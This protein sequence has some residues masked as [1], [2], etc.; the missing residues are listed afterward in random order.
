MRF[1]VRYHTFY[2][3]NNNSLR[4]LLF[5]AFLFLTL[6]LSAQSD[7]SVG[8]I[9]KRLVEVL[10]EEHVKPR[11]LDENLAKAIHND[12]MSSLDDEK[13][14]FSNEDIDELEEQNPNIVSDIT[15]EQETYLNTVKKIYNA[16]LESIKGY[17]K[18]FFAAELDLEKP[19]SRENIEMEE[20][21]P[22]SLLGAKWDV[23]FR[24]SIM[25]DVISTLEET[26]FEFN[27]DSLNYIVTDAKTRVESIYSDYFINIADNLAFID[28]IY[29]NSIA[30][31]YDPHSNYF[32]FSQNKEFE[33]ELSSERELFGVS[34]FKNVKGEMEVTSIVPGSS[35]WLSGQVRVGDVIREIKFGNE[36][37]VVL[38]GKT[39]F[40][41]NKLFDDNTSDKVLLTLENENDGIKPVELLKTKVYS[42]DDIIKS[43]LLN[44]EKK[45]G[46]ISLPDFY[47]NWN[48]DGELG[49]ANDLAKTLIKLKKENI[50][51]VILDLR[52]NGGGS[53]KESIDLTGIFI[54]YGPI[55]VVDGD[56]EKPYTYKDFNRGAIYNGPLIVM[57]NENSASASEVV[58]GA[59]QDYN[60]A[61]IVGQKSFGKATGQS[62]H[63]VA[64]KSG[65]TA[66][67]RNDAWGFVKVTEIGLYRIDLETNQFNG[68]TP[69]IRLEIPLD[70]DPF[71]EKDYPNV[72]HLDSIY[73]KMYYTAKPEFDLDEIASRSKTRQES[74]TIFIK[75]QTFND[76]IND[77]YEGVE[78]D[79][80][81][82][83]ERIALKKELNK[84]KEE[85]E[86]L[87][88]GIS[89]QFTSESLQY[90]EDVYKMSE[91]L[92][93]YK[94]AFHE[95]IESDI[96]LAETYEI[97][98]EIINK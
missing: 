40:Q 34:Y 46:Y 35:A 28:N 59:L 92:N 72:I 39:R 53:L 95:E 80:L 21:V 51:G 60:R 31:S 65:T 43:A 4:Q 58:A 84:I 45:I 91:Y 64:P 19:V 54:D 68:V 30:T 85:V 82:L 55:L 7:I 5:I 74:A 48:D 20:T 83:T 86:E 37:A 33:Q 90:D 79:F 71:R 56:K 44:G 67:D 11:T 73:K 87:Y 57:I 89:N 27:A 8:S 32:S 76:Q 50:D 26:D 24:N 38:K 10:D 69:D 42:D 61:V 94:E 36:K 9:S 25:A 17:H 81:T 3:I 52:D 49:C 29:L 70:Y 16:N 14:F 15:N 98:L 47:T 62:V 6:T 63:A 75:M 93:L 18:S 23:I 22:K 77:L 41:L 97:L 96:E 66:I 88:E 1:F 2:A 13:I 78:K 12:M